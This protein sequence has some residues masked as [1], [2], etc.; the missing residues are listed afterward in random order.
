V[1][2]LN[3]FPGKPQYFAVL[4]RGQYWQS[5]KGYHGKEIGSTWFSGSSVIRHG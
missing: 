2:G 3:I 1:T 4:R 5:V